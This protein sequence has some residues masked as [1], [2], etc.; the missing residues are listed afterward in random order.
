M[1]VLDQMNALV[2]CLC[3]KLDE[4]EAP[5]CFCGIRAGEAVPA[6]MVDCDDGRCGQAWVRMRNAYPS[7]TPGSLDQTVGNCGKG[8]GFDLEIGILRCVEIDDLGYLVDEAGALDRQLKDMDIM[9]EAIVCCPS[10][11]N[12]DYML[13]QYEPVGPMGGTLGGAWTLYLG[14]M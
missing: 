11:R 9:Q 1:S 13:G 6:D 14:S 12:P 3:Q 4:H 10:I 5:T 8:K 2:V 7:M